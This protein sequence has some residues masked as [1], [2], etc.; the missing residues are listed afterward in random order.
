MKIELVM[1]APELRD[2]R[3]RKEGQE[4][5][6]RG[7][8]IIMVDGERWGRTYVTWHGCNGT[9]TVFEQHHGDVITKSIGERGTRVREVSV[10][11]A[12]ERHAKRFIDGQY[13]LPD[14]FKSTEHLVLDKVRELIDGDLL[15]HPDIVA[16]EANEIAAKM[17]AQRITRHERELAEFKAKAMEAVRAN[18]PDSE[19]VARVV[20]AMRWAQTQ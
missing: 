9:K 14:D 7:E 13:R 18:D 17:E 20:E 8:R 1:P 3:T 10:S 11:S 19:I 5:F 4:F 2:W 16:K 12:S 15:R 6:E